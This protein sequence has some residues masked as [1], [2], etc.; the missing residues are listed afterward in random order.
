MFVSLYVQ[1]YEDEAHGCILAHAMGLGKSLQTIAL[2]HTYH[3]YFPG[4]R[5]LLI[6]PA[7]VLGNW[8]EEFVK[9]LPHAAPNSQQLIV[10]RVSS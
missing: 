6:V 7:N 9:W 2:L 10:K 4:H 8:K 1:F 3:G 5:S